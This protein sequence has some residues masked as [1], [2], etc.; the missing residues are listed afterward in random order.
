M[1]NIGPALLIIRLLSAGLQLAGPAFFLIISFL[2]LF[3]F[4]RWA[5][6]IMVVGCCLRI[7]SA[8]PLVLHTMGMLS[9]DRLGALTVPVGVADRIGSLLFA[10]GF[11]ILVIWIKRRIMDGSSRDSSL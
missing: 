11:L 4:L 1:E 7:L 6:I 3:W 5:G 2:V 8:V 10:A 9:L